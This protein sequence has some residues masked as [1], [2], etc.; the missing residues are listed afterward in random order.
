M[1]CWDVRGYLRIPASFFSCRGRCRETAQCNSGQSWRFL[2]IEPRAKM[3]STPCFSMQKGCDVSTRTPS[4]A[5]TRGLTIVRQPYSSL[6]QK[7]RAETTQKR[8]SSSS[9]LSGHY[10]ATPANHSPTLPTSAPHPSHLPC[11]QSSL[12]YLLAN[13]TQAQPT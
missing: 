5:E 11:L 3:E 1:L 6:H 8:R 13:P 2:R 7:E 9:T 4:S 12:L 10:S